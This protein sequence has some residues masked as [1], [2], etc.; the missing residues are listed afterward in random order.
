MTVLLFYNILIMV[1]TSG[2]KYI[3][4]SGLLLCE[5]S[6]F[7]KAHWSPRSVCLS[8]RLL[9][10]YRSHR[11]SDRPDFLTV[12]VWQLMTKDYGIFFWKSDN[13]QGQGHHFC[14]NQIMGHIFLTGSGRDFWLHDVPS[15]RG[16]PFWRHVF[17]SRDFKQS[18]KKITYSNRQ[19]QS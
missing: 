13:G 18:D 5:I 6:D 19:G 16:P 3:G 8:V 14:E 9:T 12:D 2:C 17:T 15:A 1:I 7:R 11:W 4:H 10:M